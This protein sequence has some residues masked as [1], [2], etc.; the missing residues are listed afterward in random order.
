MDGV[1]TTERWS[2]AYLDEMREVGDPIAD[3]AVRRIFESPD[4]PDAQH[5][6]A[7]MVDNDELPEVIPEVL[8]AYLDETKPP[9]TYDDRQVELGAEVFAAYGPEIMLILACY[10]LPASYAAAKGVQVLHRTGFLNERPNRRLVETVQFVIDVMSPGGLGSDGYGIR[11]AQKVRLMHASIRHLILNNK[12]NPWNPEWG[13]PINQEDLAGTLSTF[14]WVVMDGLDKLRIE[15]SDAQ[16]QA[17]LDRWRLVGHV[18]GLRPELIPATMDEARELTEIVQRRQVS[19]SPEGEQMMQALL[20]LLR[21][22]M[23]GEMLD[24]TCDAL[25]RH[26]LPEDVADSLG[27]RE[28]GVGKAAVGAIV[29]VADGLDAIFREDDGERSGVY[30]NLGLRFVDLFMSY[31]RKGKHRMPFRLPQGVDEAWRVA[32]I[33]EHA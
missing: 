4:L 14:T 27:V 8:R 30:R 32:A 22:R 18:I 26:F 24:G 9:T 20:G 19:P 12:E 13:V 28:C 7:T 2:D 29:A 11:T 1:E 3:A 5:F 17:Y 16:K 6:M 10:S 25:V 31:E 23:P 15:L 21:D 33:D